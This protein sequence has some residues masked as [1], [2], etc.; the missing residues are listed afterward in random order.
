MVHGFFA[1]L[2]FATS[3]A[4]AAPQGGE[5][6]FGKGNL[7]HPALIQQESQLL[8]TSWQSF[9]IAAGEVVAVRQPN[10]QA[11]LHIKVRSGAA[12][13][14]HGTLTANG[15]IA[16]ENP[17]GI[18]F[19]AGAVV[20]VGGLLASSAHG[21][22][23]VLG[24][25]LAT[26]QVRLKSESGMVNV[27]GAI[28]SPAIEIWSN[29][30]TNFQGRLETKNLSLIYTGT[31]GQPIPPWAVASGRSLSFSAEQIIL[32]P[33]AHEI[34][35]STGSDLDFCN[36][37]GSVCGAL[38][39]SAQAISFFVGRRADGSAVDYPI[40]ASAINFAARDSVHIFY[41]GNIQLAALDGD[42]VLDTPLIQAV[43]F[44]PTAQL[45]LSLNVFNASKGIIFP[46]ATTFILDDIELGANN[47]RATQDLI[48]NSPTPAGQLR[49]IKQTNITARTLSLISFAVAHPNENLTITTENNLTID[50]ALNAQTGALHLTSTHGVIDFV[51][52]PNLQGS[53]FYLS[54]SGEPFAALAPAQ[55]LDENGAATEGTQKAPRLTYTGTGEQ[56]QVPWATWEPSPPPPPPEPPTITPPTAIVPPATDKTT[57]FLTGLFGSDGIFTRFGTINEEGVLDLG[58]YSIKLHIN[59]DIFFPDTLRKVKAE[60]INFEANNIYRGADKHNKQSIERDFIFEARKKIILGANFESEGNVSFVGGSLSFGNHETATIR[61]ARS[62]IIKTDELG[63]GKDQNVFLRAIGLVVL[64]SAVN[65]GKGDLLVEEGG[66]VKPI[67]EIT[68]RQREILLKEE[69]NQGKEEE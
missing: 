11:T 68:M 69:L 33:E 22:I 8:K 23:E 50:S 21:A 20:N 40:R 3:V 60:E 10:A 59:G 1:F 16:L 18:V 14:I 61:S 57:F 58:T 63:N 55:F 31:E 46:Q 24:N 9:D 17:A 62:I 26:T 45:R 6:L 4:V 49:F 67:G 56:A 52:T 15:N 36:G 47:I 44:F 25:V 13:N 29:D 51:Q 53:S 54:Q 7:S 35:E 34:G 2:L 12:T 42:I 5:I 48:F 39:L 28:V 30:F 65:I 32:L 37:D 27:G 43:K 19:G 64:N 41:Q 38:S 66:M